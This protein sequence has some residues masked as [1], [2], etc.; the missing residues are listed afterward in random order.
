MTH[1]VT[2][3]KQLQDGTNKVDIQVGNDENLKEEIILTRKKN[4]YNQVKE[5]YERLIRDLSHQVQQLQQQV[6]EFYYY[7][8]VSCK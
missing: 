6:N 3:L 5:E 1:A 4:Q 7:T 8:G 2:N